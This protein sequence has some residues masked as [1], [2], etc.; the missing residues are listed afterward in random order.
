MLVSKVLRKVGLNRIVYRYLT[1]FP[2]KKLYIDEDTIQESWK[3]LED[4]HSD[5]V[6]SCLID[7]LISQNPKY[8]LVII[9]PSYNVKSYIIDCIDSIISQQTTVRFQIKVIDDGSTDGTW[10][11]LQKYD[12]FSNVTLIRKNNG[13]S[14]SALNT[15]LKEIEAKYVMFVDADDQLMPNAIQSLFDAANA[16]QEADIVEGQYE[17]FNSHRIICRSNSMT[18]LGD[19][20]SVLQGY[21][22]LK[23]YKA[24]LFNGIGFPEGCW[25]QDTVGL[26]VRYG[27]ARKVMVIPDVIYRYRQNKTGISFSAKKSYK[28]IDSFWVTKKL[29][30]DKKELGQPFTHR[31]YEIFLDQTAHNIYRIAWADDER[32]KEAVFV[33]S[34]VLKNVYFPKM[35][36]TKEKCRD[37]ETLMENANCRNFLM[38]CKYIY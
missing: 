1:F 21:Q 23:I 17:Y 9:I 29:L 24:F 16:H 11:L 34:I 6:K 5:K 25:H 20:W 37:I 3:I 22:W 35:K 30:E 13:G 7:N 32:V 4:K 33:L 28:A 10:E 18:G 12:F 31:D 15:G 2:C 36:A 19:D 26:M 8:D 38:Y 27:Y 14:G